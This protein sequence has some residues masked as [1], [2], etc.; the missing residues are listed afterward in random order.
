VALLVHV[1]NAVERCLSGRDLVTH[2]DSS[3]AVSM[4]RFKST[5]NVC[6]HF[7]AGNSLALPL[8]FSRRLIVLT[9]IIGPFEQNFHHFYITMIQAYLVPSE[10]SR[11]SVSVIGVLEYEE[12]RNRSKAADRVAQS[13]A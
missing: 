4:R 13:S 3:G 11:W 7:T 2:A 1:A 9:V 8:R 12:R 10:L 5:P 6:A